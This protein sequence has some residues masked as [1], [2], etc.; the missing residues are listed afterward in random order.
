MK[1]SS[2]ADLGR[3]ECPPH[4]QTRY[5][6]LAVHANRS[7]SHAVVSRTAALLSHFAT[8]R[9]ARFASIE[10]RGVSSRHPGPRGEGADRRITGFG[11]R[12]RKGTEKYGPRGGRRRSVSKSV[13]ARLNL[14]ACE[15]API[16]SGMPLWNAHPRYSSPICRP[17]N[18]I[19]SRSVPGN[20]LRTCLSSASQVLLTLA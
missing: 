18:Q 10:V 3:Q 6:R 7:Q 14:F 9:A 19:A 12:N 5:L 20:V 13:S 16:T 8:V 4:P 2:P 11:V 15:T 17:V 1:R